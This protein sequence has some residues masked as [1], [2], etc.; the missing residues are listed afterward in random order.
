[1]FFLEKIILHNMFSNTNLY[2]TELKKISV[3][4]FLV[5]TEKV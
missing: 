4:T 2:N 1:M 5:Y 3:S